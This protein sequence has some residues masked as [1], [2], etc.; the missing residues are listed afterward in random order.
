MNKLIRHCICRGYPIRA[1]LSVCLLD[2]RFYLF[3]SHAPVAGGHLGTSASIE[4]VPRLRSTADGGNCCRQ[5]DC[6]SLGGVSGGSARTSLHL[7][8]KLD[9]LTGDGD[10]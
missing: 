10:E 3:A 9:T 5:E 1:A 8:E 7:Q 4:Q 6:Q 2:F